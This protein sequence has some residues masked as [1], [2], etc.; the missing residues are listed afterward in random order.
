MSRKIEKNKALLQLLLDL[1]TP[2]NQIEALLKSLSDAQIVVLGEIAHNLLK[3]HLDLSAKAKR[4][5]KKNHH[6]LTRLSGKTVSLNSKAK[7]IAKHWKKVF[8]CL[9]E[10][11]DILLTLIL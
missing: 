1:R 6:I 8:L 3:G 7:I 10:T 9:F 11:R 4:T 2:K 5:I